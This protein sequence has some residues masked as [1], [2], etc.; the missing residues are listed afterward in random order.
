MIQTFTPMAAALRV[1][2]VMIEYQKTRI[3]TGRHV[4]E[5]KAKISGGKKTGG[6]DQDTEPLI[7]YLISEDS[8]THTVDY[9]KK[10]RNDML[11]FDNSIET[12]T[13]DKTFSVRSTYD[14]VSNFLCLS[15]SNILI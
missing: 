1:D 4:N 11:L 12:R 13:T 5:P 10:F 6:R 9:I 2:E 8:D 14:D 3:R 7:P 15:F